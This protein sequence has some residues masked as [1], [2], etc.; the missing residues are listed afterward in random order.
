M[1]F[2]KIYTRYFRLFLDLLERIP[3]IYMAREPRDTRIRDTRC[4]PGP[5]P[6]RISGEH[7]T[8]KVAR[9]CG[10][11]GFPAGGAS[12]RIGERLLFH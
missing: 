4:F 10:L 7:C 1:G 8:G 12:A 11:Q 5:Y 9:V 6:S 3:Y 2:I